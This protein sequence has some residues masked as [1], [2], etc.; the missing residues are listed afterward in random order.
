MYIPTINLNLGPR[1]S[2]AGLARPRIDRAEGCPTS[3]IR[4]HVEH[5][6]VFRRQAQLTHLLWSGGR[7]YARREEP[8]IGLAGDVRLGWVP[9]LH[10]VPVLLLVLLVVLVL[11]FADPPTLGVPLV[12]AIVRCP[13][14]FTRRRPRT[15]TRPA[16]HVRTATSASPTFA[17]SSWRIKPRSCRR[18]SYRR[19]RAG[20][21]PRASGTDERLQ[22]GYS[23]CWNR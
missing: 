9:G 8:L 3:R 11:I 21:H 19:P 13:A 12:S 7:F 2:R 22:R 1:C 23:A 15:R 17:G 16:M 5:L 20:S 6:N 10:N 14:S 18:V 4:M